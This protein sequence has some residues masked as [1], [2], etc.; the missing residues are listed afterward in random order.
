[1]A[2]NSTLNTTASVSP[3]GSWNMPILLPPV[4]S[5]NCSSSSAVVSKVSSRPPNTFSTLIWFLMLKKN[6]LGEH[7]VPVSSGGRIQYPPRASANTTLPKKFGSLTAALVI[8]KMIHGSSLV[9]L[10]C[11]FRQICSGLSLSGEARRLSSGA[12]S[13]PTKSLA[14]SSPTASPSAVCLSMP[15]YSSTSRIIRNIFR[16]EGN[17]RSF[18]KPKAPMILHSSTTFVQSK[19]SMMLNLS[20]SQKLM[21]GISG[22]G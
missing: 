22:R 20:L 8:V 11:T 18:A 19:R 3:L 15:T 2:G 5:N 16:L 13:F 7:R 12:A 10:A 17:F 14:R 21:S 1:M 4:I 9:V 6:P